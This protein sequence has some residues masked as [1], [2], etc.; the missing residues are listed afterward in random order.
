[1]RIPFSVYLMPVFWFALYIFP[2]T[3]EALY[4]FAILHLLLYPAS[5]GYNSICDKDEGPIGGLAKPPKPN[6]ELWVLVI[7]FDVLAVFFSFLI[8]VPFGI[9]VVAYTLVSKA[10][11]WPAIRLKAN[12]WASTA[13]VVLFQGM[14]TFFMVMVG[15]GMPWFLLFERLTCMPAVVSSL[16]ILGSYPLTQVYQHEEDAKRGDRTISLQLGVKKTFGLSMLALG[17]A[18]GVLALYALINLFESSHPLE[19]HFDSAFSIPQFAVY[20]VL[21]SPILYY[22]FKWKKQVEQANWQATHAQTMRFNAIAS[23]SMSGVFIL[24]LFLRLF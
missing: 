7:G 13:V 1:M 2:R 23:M 24:L 20:L 12:P 10:Y 4:V 5:N 17:L 8:S 3:N 18:N 14:F 22:F 6:A 19:I 16:F 9:M 11:S 21:T 15:L